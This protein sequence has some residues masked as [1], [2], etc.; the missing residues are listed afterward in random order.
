[1]ADIVLRDLDDQLKEKLRRRAASNR[2]SMNAELREIVR[3]ALTA[4]W[5]ESCRAPQA[6]GGDPRSQRRPPANALGRL[7]P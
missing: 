1:M 7:A 4:P 3:A 6:G 5:A 2:R